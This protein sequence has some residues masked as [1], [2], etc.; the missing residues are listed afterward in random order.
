MRLDYIVFEG[1]DGVGKTTLSKT[2]AKTIDAIWRYEPDGEDN[3]SRILRNLCLDKSFDRSVNAMAREYMMLASRSISTAEVKRILSMA[4]KVV[5]DRSFISGAAYALTAS[6]IPIEEWFDL[7]ARAL[8][9]YP[10]II[11]YVKGEQKL[12]EGNN[13]IY[14]SEDANF[15]KRLELSFMQVLTYVSHTKNI[16]V[17]EFVNSFELTPQENTKRLLGQLESLGFK[18]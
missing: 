12:K 9:C 17:V 14:D 4:D 6:H 13:D 18:R 2:Y 5:Q 16:P 3:V 11:V 8:H 7:G 10:D 15:F 1:M